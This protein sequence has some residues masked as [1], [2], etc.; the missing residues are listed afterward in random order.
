[1]KQLPDSQLDNRAESGFTLTDTLTSLLLGII[2]ISIAGATGSIVMSPSNQARCLNNLRTL[3]VAWSV[4]ADENADHLVG[5][6]T[7]TNNRPDWVGTDTWMDLNSAAPKNFDPEIQLGQSPLLP[8]L[9]Q[10]MNR[11]SAF[12]LFKCP[13][14]PSASKHSQYNHGRLTPRARSY[15]MNNW[16]GGLRWI[17]PSWIAFSTRSELTELSP[18]KAMVFAGERAD[19]INDAALYIDMNGYLDSNTLSG[20]SRIIDFPALYHG[21]GA[22]V[23]FADGHVINKKWRDPRTTPVFDLTRELALNISS[24]NNPDVLWLQDHATRRQ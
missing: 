24:P 19:S 7:T 20:N 15:S 18:S 4:Y 6:G 8:Y 23:S 1:M 17:M 22:S 5:V 3:T 2:L 12:Q 11:A 16:M 13:A 21:G 14:D 10:H 9:T